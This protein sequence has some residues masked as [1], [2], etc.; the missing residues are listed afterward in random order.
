[1]ISHVHRPAASGVRS[2]GRVQP[3]VCL[4]IRN[5]CSRSKRRRNA[6]HRT[7]TASAVKPVAEDHSHSGSGSP[8]PGSR[9]TSRRINVPSMMGSSPSLSIQA[10]RVV[11]RGWMRSQAIARAVPYR[12]VTCTVAVFGSPQV[13]GLAKRNSLPCLGGR[14]PWGGEIHGLGTGLRMTRSERS[15]PRTS[16]GR[17]AS[18][19]AMRGAS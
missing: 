8:P 9:S 2:F 16:T 19:W 17:P 10:E 5:V 6:C 3:S 15:R 4:I 7:S 11:S 12:S 1:M 18:R 13:S 14:P